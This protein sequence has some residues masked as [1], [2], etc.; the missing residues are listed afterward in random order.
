MFDSDGSGETK[1][2]SKKKKVAILNADTAADTGYAL[3]YSCATDWWMFGI[4]RYTENAWVLSRSDTI[5]EAKFIDLGN[6]L[7]SKV[8]N[9]DFG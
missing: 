7:M 1:M 4:P 8:P 5:D 3:V 2:L 9:Y 6:E